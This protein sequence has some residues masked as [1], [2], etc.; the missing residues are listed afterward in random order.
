MQQ[1]MDTPCL[2]LMATDNTVSVHFLLKT[3]IHLKMKNE[4]K[5]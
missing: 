2:S 5:D 1:M 4:K 3:L